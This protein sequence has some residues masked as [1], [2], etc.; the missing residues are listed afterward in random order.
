MPANRKQRRAF[1]V[2]KGGWSGRI[3]DPAGR[4]EISDGCCSPMETCCWRINS[5][6]AHL[7]EKKVLWNLDAPNGTEIHTAMP[8]GAE[9]VLYV[10]NGDL[11]S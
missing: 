8:I 4:G 6:E 11:R 2:R 7:A 10:Q 3:C 5:R 1:I 9:H